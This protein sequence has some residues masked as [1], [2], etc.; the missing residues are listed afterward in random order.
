MLLGVALAGVNI[1]LI[2]ADYRNQLEQFVAR[3]SLELDRKLTILNRLVKQSES[4]LQRIGGIVPTIADAVAPGTPIEE[5]WAALQLDLEL[6]ALQLFDA[7]GA[8]LLRGLPH[9]GAR[10]P[11]ILA[12]RVAAALMS[13]RPDSFLLC[14]DTCAQYA[15][16]PTISAQ[17]QPRVMLVATQLTDLVVQFPQLADAEIALITPTSDPHQEARSAIWPG[18]R[19]IAISDAPRN[20]PKLQALAENAE[21]HEL[22]GGKGFMFGERSYRVAARDLRSFGSLDPGYVLIFGDLTAELATIR[23][24]IQRG[25]VSG[26][27]ALLVALLLGLAI[28]NRPMNQLRRLADALPLL[29]SKAYQPARQ[30]I[31]TDFLSRRLPTEI[32]VLEGVAVE[33]TDQLETL[34]GLV[35]TRNRA[36]AE[37][38]AELRRSQELNEKIFATAPIVMIMQSGGG[39]IIQANEFACTLMGYSPTELEQTNFLTLLADERQRKQTNNALIDLI[40]GRRPAFEQT[41]PV[42]CVD[43]SLERI[44]WLHSRVQAQ[45]GI[46]VLS[47]GLPDK[48]EQSAPG[49]GC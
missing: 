40:S 28:L 18:L 2:T 26:G 8:L 25:F 36:L 49:A 41:G 13:E 44:T 31:G 11:K 39:E 32:E 9:F 38:I 46:F 5:S 22:F 21:I 7:E 30:L 14:D 29:A 15:L 45:S 37:N 17:G 33:L 24:Q 4:R 34:E 10:P 12:M 35:E 43:G 23:R 19:L 16:V 48:S 20:E 42:L 47:L 6:L 27:T 1:S 3:Q